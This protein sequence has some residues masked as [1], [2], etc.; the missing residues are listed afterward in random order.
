VGVG[1]LGRGLKDLGA[2]VRIGEG[3][4]ATLEAIA[5]ATERTVSRA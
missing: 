3:L 5:R 2:D 4:E 1:A